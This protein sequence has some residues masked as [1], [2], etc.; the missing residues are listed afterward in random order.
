M[1]RKLTQ[2]DRERIRRMLD[3]DTHEAI[4]EQFGVS[5][6]TIDR[7]A[8]YWDAH[9]VTVSFK[10]EGGRLELSGVRVGSEVGPVD[11]DAIAQ[12]AERMAAGVDL[13]GEV[14]TEAE[15]R[16]IMAEAD[17]IARELDASPYVRT[18]G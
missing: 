8:A 9:T 1:N 3:T 2:G 7:E 6:R 18:T 16:S 14:L 13:S 5:T 10:T 15:L 4:A 17:R 11:F 12:E